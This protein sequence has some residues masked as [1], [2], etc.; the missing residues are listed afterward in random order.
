METDKENQGR[1]QNTAA[2]LHLQS[3]ESSCGSPVWLTDEVPQLHPQSRE[4]RCGSQVWLTDV[5]H[6]GASAA[7]LFCPQLGIPGELTVC[8]TSVP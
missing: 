8:V 4:S 2:W 6:T 5:A 3:S 7:H 1:S